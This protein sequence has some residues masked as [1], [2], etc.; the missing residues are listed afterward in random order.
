MPPHARTWRSP[1]EV[2]GEMKKIY[3]SAL[4]ATSTNWYI[5]FDFGETKAITEFL[6][7]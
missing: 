4:V 6:P 7:E 1:R 3:E 5:D 2:C